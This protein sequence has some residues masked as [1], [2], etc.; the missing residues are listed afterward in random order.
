MAE[1]DKKFHK[2]V[3]NRPS[4]KPAECGKFPLQGKIIKLQSMPPAANGPW[5]AFVVLTTKPTKV[6]EDDK[7]RDSKPGEEVIICNTAGL[8]ELEE[9]AM[10]KATIHEVIIA[11]P[12]KIDTK[13]GQMW[14]Y[15]LSYDDG[16]PRPAQYALAESAA[17]PRLPAGNQ[18]Q[19]PF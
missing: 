11:N 13:N 5:E 16:E 17:A 4:W 14:A 9:Y 19:I 18:E 10:K 6:V 15:D 8:R 2:I 3:R 12:K 7:V 1:A